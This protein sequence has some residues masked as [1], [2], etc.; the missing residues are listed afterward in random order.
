[1]NLTKMIYKPVLRSA[2]KQAIAGRNRSKDVS[3]KGRFSSTDVNQRLAQ[4]WRNFDQLALGLP[5]EPNYRQPYDGIARLYNPFMPSGLTRFGN[6]E[7]LCHS[8]DCR[9]CLENIRKMGRSAISY[10]RL[11]YSQFCSANAVVI[12]LNGWSLTR[13][14]LSICTVAPSLCILNRPMLATSACHVVNLNICALQE[15]LYENFTIA[16]RTLQVGLLEYIIS[17]ST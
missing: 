2:A 12:F 1:M 15:N 6:R 14:Y 13:A 11:F 5:K 9:C 4:T 10:Y 17:R 7:G 16:I 3:S 8:T